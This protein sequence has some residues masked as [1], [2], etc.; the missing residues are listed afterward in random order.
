MS[1]LNF[2]LVEIKNFIETEIPD[3]EKG[4]LLE[5]L[6]ATDSKEAS[7]DSIGE[8]FFAESP[9]L[10]IPGA[11]SAMG[12][13]P[14]GR[15]DRQKESILPKLKKEIYKVLC[16]EKQIKHITNFKDFVNAVIPIIASRLNANPQDITLLVTASV[17]FA[18]SNGII[19][20]CENN[21]CILDQ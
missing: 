4:E 1:E 5:L 7:L 18:L 6:T 3:T 19:N 11:M 8:K 9:S 2:S 21:K 10:S 17:I 13:M 15:I 12:D 14:I 20:F 16:T